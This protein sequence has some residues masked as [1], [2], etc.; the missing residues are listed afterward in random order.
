M[1][2]NDRGMKKREMY[3]DQKLVHKLKQ[4]ILAMPGSFASASGHSLD[5]FEPIFI[6]V[7]V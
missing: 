1:R 3:I 2:E 7:P 4:T 6:R 5:S